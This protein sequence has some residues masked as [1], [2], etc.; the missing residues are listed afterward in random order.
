MLELLKTLV[1]I[2][3]VSGAEEK[4]AH[5][6]SDLLTEKGFSVNRQKVDKNRFNV[7]AT[8]EPAPVILFC[9]HMDTVPPFIPF[10]RDG[11]RLYGRGVCDAKGA[12]VCM[13]EAGLQL[14]EEGLTSFGFLFVV[15]EETDSDGARQA[16]A[17]GLETKY[18]I[19]GE[20]TQ[21]RLA[22]GQKGTLV[23]QIEATGE[24]GHSAY[25]ER[26][27]S[28]IH[29]LIHFLNRLQNADWSRDDYFGQTTVNIGKIEGGYSAN[30]IS[31]FAR[32]EGIFRISRDCSSTETHLRSL[33]DEGIKITVRSKTEPQHLGRLKDFQTTIVAFGS[34]AGHLQPLGQVYLLGPGSIEFAH[35]EHEQITIADLETAVK[36]YRKMVMEL[37]N[38]SDSRK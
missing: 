8:L 35:Q 33:A 24:L 23:F 5:L 37:I 32:A 4:I 18:I 31:D 29:H 26:G 22:A 2:P 9:T 16:A 34:D 12:L 27:R 15:G 19:L 10:Q 3:S 17:L 14:V 13:I 1:N 7:L 25:P 21:N 28:A 11:Q 20:P 6:L 36:L 38:R 30:V